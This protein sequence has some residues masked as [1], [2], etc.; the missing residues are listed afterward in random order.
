MLKK[1][2]DTLGKSW[3]MV[4][5][6][7]TIV[8]C[9]AAV[10][11]VPEVRHWL[12]LDGSQDETHSVTIEAMGISASPY[13]G[14]NFSYLGDSKATLSTVVGSDG[15]TQYWLDYEISADNPGQAILEFKF[16]KLQNLV[17]YKYI[18]FTIDFVLPE[19]QVGF[20]LENENESGQG[21]AIAL[22]TDRNIENVLVSHLENERYTFQIPLDRFT[23]TN[24]SNVSELGIYV[25]SDFTTGKGKIMIENILFE[26][27]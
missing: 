1:L 14:D 26:V 20:Y 4:L 8:A 16:Q 21:D 12:G 15:I 24:M 27:P 23:D 11:V 13:S 22:S 3:T 6:M 17:A 7:A 18:K 9:V 19:R 5:G 2:W 25:H 10:I